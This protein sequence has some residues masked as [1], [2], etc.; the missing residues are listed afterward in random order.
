M[1]KLTKEQRKEMAWEEYKKIKDSAYEEYKKIEN[2]ALEEYLKIKIPAYEEYLKKIKEIDKEPEEIP[3]IIEQNGKKYKLG[4]MKEF[5]LSEKREKL[6]EDLINAN[7]AKNTINAIV[8]EVEEQDKEF[9][10]K[11]KERDCM[12][13]DLSL[14]CKTC[15]NEKRYFMRDASMCFDCYIDKLAG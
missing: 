15:G 5:N 4:R 7:W 10:K 11:L 2:P 12:F 3:E 1:K 9:I 13:S 6:R 8:D 14:I